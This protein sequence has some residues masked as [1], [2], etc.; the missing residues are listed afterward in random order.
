MARQPNRI[1]DAEQA[2][3]LRMALERGA[4]SPADASR[5]LR[6]LGGHSQAEFAAEVGLN[7]KVIRSLESGSGNPRFDSLQK[8]AA[9]FGLRV[10][11]VKPSLSIEL[12]DP[13]ARAADERRRREADA[14]ALQVGRISAHDLHRRNA[15]QVGEVSFELPKLT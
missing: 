8:I 14:E 11:F 13:D 5:V 12:M 1:R 15:L 9:A 7:L 10:A 2:Q 4:F 3:A 6:A